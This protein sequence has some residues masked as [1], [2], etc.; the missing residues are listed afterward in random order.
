MGPWQSPVMAT[1]TGGGG[2]EA[3]G[4]LPH[5]EFETYQYDALGRLQYKTDFNGKQTTYNYDLLDRVLSESSRSVARPAAEGQL[6]LHAD[7]T[8]A[9]HDRQERRHELYGV[10]Q[11]RPPEDQS[12]AR[13]HFELHLRRARQRADDC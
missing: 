9:L 5:L 7:R 11:P 1:A 13:R 8:A 3:S 10:R 6:Y 12:D 2:I 4:T